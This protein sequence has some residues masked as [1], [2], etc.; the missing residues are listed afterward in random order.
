M[1]ATGN[2]SQVL[3]VPFPNHSRGQEGK[4]GTQAPGRGERP[5]QVSLGVKGSGSESR[6]PADRP[7]FRA[8]TWQI[9]TFELSPLFFPWCFNRDSQKL[10]TGNSDS[11]KE[12]KYF[13]N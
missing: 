8:E 9:R 10:R 3:E 6:H 11:G 13:C 7:K 1:I 5:F 4:A 2:G 12:S